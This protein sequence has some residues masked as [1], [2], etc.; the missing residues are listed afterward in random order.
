MAKIVINKNFQSKYLY[1]AY[2]RL[3]KPDYSINTS[4]IKT[5]NNSTGEVQN[6]TVGL[7]NAPVQAY[8]DLSS[9]YK[10]TWAGV[11][12]TASI[13]YNGVPYDNAQ[14]VPH[15][16]FLCDETFLTL[17][18]KINKTAKNGMSSFPK[19]VNSIDAT[20][21]TTAN[22]TLNLNMMLLSATLFSPK[23]TIR[24][25]AID[26]FVQSGIIT[27][28]EGTQIKATT[29]TFNL[30]DPNVSIDSYGGKYVPKITDIT[31]TYTSGTID[32][33][34]PKSLRLDNP[35]KAVNNVANTSLYLLVI[36]YCD[37]KFVNGLLNKIVVTFSAPALSTEQQP[38]G[39]VALGSE[40]YMESDIGIIQTGYNTFHNKAT[41]TVVNQIPYIALS[42]TEVGQGGDIEFDH[43]D[44]IEYFDEIKI[45]MTLPKEYV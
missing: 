24:D 45:S 7:N 30:I 26:Y 44:E 17:L 42:I 25:N 16:Y 21:V 6:W 9:V 15:Q 12:K 8:N 36:P 22:K 1:R 43:L 20:A 13:T 14:L 3:V 33:S 19:L 31:T 29:S 27:S 39:T 4:I 37:T 10:T 38:N 28:T 32:M 5:R 35:Y 23:K 2:E 18:N 40:C 11:D 34:L 41:N